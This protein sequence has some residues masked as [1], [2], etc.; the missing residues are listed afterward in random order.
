MKNIY[1]VGKVYIWQ[2]C[3]GDGAVL[4]GQET[5][6]TGNVF[7]AQHAETGKWAPA[8]PTSTPNPYYPGTFTNAAAGVL[9]PKNPP[10]GEQSIADMFKQILVVA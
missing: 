3:T 7:M 1:E 8:Q 10:T 5:T 2:N 9:R 4:N 6:V